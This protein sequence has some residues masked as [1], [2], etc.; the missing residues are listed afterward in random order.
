MSAATRQPC[1][2]AVT[3]TTVL[4]FGETPFEQANCDVVV[5]NGRIAALDTGVVREYAPRTLIDGRSLVLTPGLYNAHTHSLETLARGLADASSLRVWLSRVWSRMDHLDNDAI[6]TAIQLCAAE[7]LHGGVTA[8]VDH[9]R[10]TPPRA[11]AIDAAAEAWLAT[12]MRATLAIMVRDR[13]VPDWVEHPANAEVQL[14]RVQA[15]CDRWQQ[16]DERLR[17]AIGPSAPT[18]CS[19]A[20]L[21]A[22]GRVCAARDLRLHMH[23]DETADESRLAKAQFGTSAV[24]HLHE[25]GLLGA[26]VSL[27]HCVCC[28][29][30]DLDVLART[31]AGVV[32]NPLSNLR[33]GSGRAPVERMLARGIPVAL[34]TDGAASNDSQNVLEAVKL[35]AYL[36]RLALD[37]PREWVRAADAL[38]MAT[39][40]AATLFGMSEARIAPGC[41][42]DFA[43]FDRAQH[44]LAPTNDLYAQLAFA[45][46]TLRARH[47]VIA[48][49]VVLKDHV[50]QTFDEPE[51][52]TGAATFTFARPS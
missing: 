18:R 40:H 42:A 2:L 15:C 38:A 3:G 44:A 5:S 22:A 8:V 25:L 11:A 39:T 47:V 28:D 29:D 24:R 10:Q 1:D 17:L 30:D 21:Q 20:L 13:N 32:H 37:D 48:G 4:S 46:A 41:V 34:G 35:A 7:M 36:P 50:I 43:A 26:H 23:V 45:G 49:Q 27:A 19:D 52:L 14:A 9:F 51:L 12:G 6:R 33:L 31:G 16:I